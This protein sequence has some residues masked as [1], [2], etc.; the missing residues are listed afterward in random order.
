MLQRRR[1]SRALTESSNATAVGG[2]TTSRSSAPQPKAR[3]A[4]TGSGDY[5]TTRRAPYCAPLRGA[6]AAL[7]SS[8]G[9]RPPLFSN[10]YGD[11]HAWLGR[12]PPGP[13]FLYLG[14]LPQ[15]TDAVGSR[16]RWLRGARRG[17]ARGGEGRGA[18]RGSRGRAGGGDAP[19]APAPAA[20][21]APDASAFAAA[22][23]RAAAAG[24]RMVSRDRDSAGRGQQFLAP[25]QHELH[26]NRRALGTAVHVEV[27]EP[28][29][30]ELLR[31]TQNSIEP[32]RTRRRTVT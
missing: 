21:A 23:R 10:F 6:A 8:G 24:R 15:R 14:R 9:P 25:Q 20:A 1:L 29:R 3:I 27:S 7:P 30:R 17:S 18:G 28:G 12:M 32:G 19:G 2:P 4:R 16:G 11:D 13:L 31:K 22:R 26:G 5:R